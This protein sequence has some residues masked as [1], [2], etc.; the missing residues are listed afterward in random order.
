MG[1]EDRYG[2]RGDLVDL[3]DKMGAFGAQPLDDMPV[4]NDFVTDV[5][6]RAVLFQRALDDL[7]CSFDP[8]AKASRLC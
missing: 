4:V 6:R 8:G 1:A 7:D 3:V 5:D 2:S